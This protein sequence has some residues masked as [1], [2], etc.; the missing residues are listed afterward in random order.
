M[1]ALLEATGFAP[2]WDCYLTRKD[3]IQM[4]GRV[5]RCHSL[6]TNLTKM[7]RVI[8]NLNHDEKYGPISDE[9]LI[10]ARRLTWIMFYFYGAMFG[11]ASWIYHQDLRK[12]VV[13]ENKV[14]FTTLL[15]CWKRSM[16]LW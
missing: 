11:F 5:M 8:Q 2:N 16:P 14:C 9:N 7:M 15:M 3:V 10:L 6:T 1:P 13:Q 12:S 4:N